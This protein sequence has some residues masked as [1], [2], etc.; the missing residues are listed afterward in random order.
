MPAIIRSE[1]QHHIWCTCYNHPLCGLLLYRLIGLHPAEVESR[2][3][4]TVDLATSLSVE[5]RLVNL[6]LEVTQAKARVTMKGYFAYWQPHLALAWRNMHKE[7]QQQQQHDATGQNSQQQQQSGQQ[8]RRWPVK[9]CMVTVEN[10][11]RHLDEQEQPESRRFRAA[12]SGVLNAAAAAAANTQDNEPG[13]GPTGPRDQAAERQYAAAFKA[14]DLPEVQRVRDTFCSPL[15]PV[16]DD[17]MWQYRLSYT[18]FDKHVFASSWLQ[19][20][21]HVLVFGRMADG[22]HPAQT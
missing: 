16:Q 3:Y 6:A 12:F 18:L 9:S 14:E 19:K 21:Q 2:E 15:V 22:K 7:Q 13:A 11:K 4:A 8:F 17:N 20:H 5:Q 1:T 10:F